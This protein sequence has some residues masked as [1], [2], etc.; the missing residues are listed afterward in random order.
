VGPRRLAGDAGDVPPGKNK[1]LA[2]GELTELARRMGKHD[3]RRSGR[4]RPTLVYMQWA[5]G[6][7]ARQGEAK[8]GGG[9]SVASIGKISQT[10]IMKLSAEVAL[11]ILGAAGMVLGDDGSTAGACRRLRVRTGKPDLRRNRQIQRN[12]AAERTL[13]S[14]GA[15]ARQGPELL[16]GASSPA[17]QTMIFA[18]SEE[19]QEF[20]NMVRRFVEARSSEAAVREQ[21]E[22][23][24]GFDPAVW[25]EMAKQLGLQGLTIPEELGGQGFGYV[26]L[27]VVLEEM[28]RSL[29]C[30]PYFSTVVLA[31]N[32]LLQAG[33][34]AA[35]R[36]SAAGHRSAKPSPR[37]PRRAE[38]AMG[39]IQHRARPQDG[40]S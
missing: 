25:S 9:A 39:R 3:D 36:A 29:L 5:T 20:R 11:D 10:R 27:M 4:S 35:K 33:D 12:I 14:Q 38:R 7:L 37:W 28:G 26:E 15:S 23:G 16:G 34:A 2:F 6:T 1:V 21:M 18:F 19:Q 24:R 32:T 8:S 40:G 13:G 30:A 17:G 22:T 31:A